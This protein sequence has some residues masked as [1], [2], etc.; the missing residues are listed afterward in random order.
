M[1]YFESDLSNRSSSK[2]YELARKNTLDFTPYMPCKI[3]NPF[4]D[5]SNS[6][7]FPKD[8]SLSKK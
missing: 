3:P 8:M 6:C 7:S 1:D 4:I 2:D 5:E